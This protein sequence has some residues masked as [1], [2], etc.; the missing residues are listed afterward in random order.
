MSKYL[1]LCTFSCHEVDDDELFTNHWKVGEFNS[2]QDC[3]D[4][5]IDDIR[6]VGEDS[7]E[8]MFDLDDETEQEKY[9]EE[10]NDYCKG[11]ELIHRDEKD[12]KLFKPVQILSN[13]YW[14]DYRR[15]ILD[16]IVIKVED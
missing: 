16:Y 12:F 9:L 1:L 10:V 15:E 8:G 11:Y 2:I 13:D 7:L 4:N 6:S 5:G 14:T 3:Y